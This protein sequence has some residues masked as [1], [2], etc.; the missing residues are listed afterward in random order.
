VG[1]G[2]IKEYHAK[3]TSSQAQQIANTMMPRILLP[4]ADAIAITTRMALIEEFIVVEILRRMMGLIV[5][6]FA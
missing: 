6:Y 4:L 1:G 2:I 5:F 3:H